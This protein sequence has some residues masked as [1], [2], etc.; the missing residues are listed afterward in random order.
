MK[1]AGFLP[2]K[3]NSLIHLKLKD[4]FLTY[5]T[6]FVLSLVVLENSILPMG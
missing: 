3:V 1:I 5:E 4:L 2:L 6:E